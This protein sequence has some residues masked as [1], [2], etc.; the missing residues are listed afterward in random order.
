MSL[1]EIVFK[2]T[3]DDHVL[4]LTKKYPSLKMI[5]WC[6]R[7]HDIIEVIVSNP[8]EYPLVMKELPK[9]EGTVA[10]VDDSRKSHVIVKVCSCMKGNSVVKLIGELG[11]LYVSP[12]I[13]EKGWQNH[14]VIAFRH[15]DWE[16]LLSRLEKAGH[17]VEVL[18]KVPFDDF[19]A[20]PLMLSADTL[21]S[22][23]TEKQMDAFLAAYRNGYYRVP[24]EVDVKA[25]A[26]QRHVPRT[27]FQEHLSK[28]ESKLAASLAPYIQ[29]FAYKLRDRGQHA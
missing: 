14:R 1:F 3:C 17:K 7:L 22:K 19:I 27:T 8:Q 15:K 2:T 29:L 13:A 16:E 21:F 12:M 26:A 25:I 20:S 28:A 5:G 9:P 4:E 6:N 24:R 23:L 18:R 10:S 11:V